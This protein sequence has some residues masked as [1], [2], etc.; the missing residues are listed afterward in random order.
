VEITV[1]VVFRRPARPLTTLII[2]PV[3]SV[4][5]GLRLRRGETDTLITWA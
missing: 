4:E 1:V 2:E 5:S 3:I